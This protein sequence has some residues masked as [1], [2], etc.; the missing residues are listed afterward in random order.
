MFAVSS[1]IFYK[2]RIAAVRGNIY[3][4]EFVLLSCE[5]AGALK[6]ITLQNF[7]VFDKTYLVKS[8]GSAQF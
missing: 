6:N 3:L 2:V 7:P 4:K 1:I 5:N 8:A